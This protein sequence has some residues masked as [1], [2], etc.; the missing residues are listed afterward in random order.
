V[1]DD[2]VLRLTLYAL[3]STPAFTLVEVMVVVAIM[4][5]VLVMGV[6]LVY[7]IIHRA[8]LNQAVQDIEDVCDNARAHAIL[9]GSAT[10][11]IWHPKDRRL[12]T[13]AGANPGKEAGPA[14]TSGHVTSAQIPDQV[15]ID[16]LDVN[17]IEYRDAEQARVRFYPNGTCDEMTV[18]LHSTGNEYREISL[19]VTT[20]L[21][22]IATDPR[23]FR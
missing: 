22:S 6:P 17:L 23:R 18:V 3:R 20:G 7:G 1:N 12:E 5:I 11:V 8:P 13:S 15:G 14:A 21:I 16:M 2:P 10:D 9:S 19:E 4:G